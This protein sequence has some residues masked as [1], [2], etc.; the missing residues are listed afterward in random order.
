VPG[1]FRDRDFGGVRSGLWSVPRAGAIAEGWSKLAY[2]PRYQKFGETIAREIHKGQIPNLQL[3][4][5]V[6]FARQSSAD[7]Y[8]SP[9]LCMLA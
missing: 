8:S 6:H 9:I 2:P 5:T 3:I 4:Q 1:N 7:C